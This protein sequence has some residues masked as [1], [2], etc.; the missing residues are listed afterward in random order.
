MWPRLGSFRAR[1]KHEMTRKRLLVAFSTGFGLSMLLATLEA[2]RHRDILGFLQFPGLVVA[3]VVTSGG[4]SSV[5]SEAGMVIVNGALYGFLFVIAW[6][7]VRL[8]HK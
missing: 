2:L 1:L 5:S 7:L 8:A 3:W 6:G 4:N